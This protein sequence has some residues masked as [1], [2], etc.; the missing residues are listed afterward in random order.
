MTRAETAHCSQGSASLSRHAEACLPVLRQQWTQKGPF[1]HW[2]TGPRW[3]SRYWRADKQALCNNSKAR[4]AGNPECPPSTCLNQRMVS[5]HKGGDEEHVEQGPGQ[6]THLQA[7]GKKDCC[8][9]ELTCCCAQQC[10]RAGASCNVTVSKLL[11]SRRANPAL[12]LLGRSNAATVSPSTSAT[13]R[14]PQ[15]PKRW[16]Q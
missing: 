8:C 11:H 14:P 3:Q 5:G 1:K 13:L 12:A 9:F 10:K 4:A 15:L 6:T 16:R 7:E 2:S